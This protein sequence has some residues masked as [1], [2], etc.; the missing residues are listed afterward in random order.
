MTISKNESLPTLD[1]QN[2]A[3]QLK[4]QALSLIGQLAGE[5]WSDHNSSDPGITILEVLAFAISDL[6][7]RLKFPIEDLL[8]GIPGEEK[9]ELFFAAQSILPSNPVTLIDHRRALIDIDGV[10]NANLLTHYEKE[11]A[12]QKATG[13]FDI[14]LDFED[15]IYAAKNKWSDVIYQVRQ[16]FVSQRNVNEDIASIQVATKKYVALTM[17]IELSKATDPVIVLAEILSRIAENIAPSINTYRHEQLI[18]KG[19]AGNEIFDGPLLEQGF[20]FAEDVEKIAMPL[21]LY[22]SDILASVRDIGSLNN[23]NHFSFLLDADDEN[24]IAAGTLGKMDTDSLHWRRDIQKNH[25]ASLNLDKTYDELILTIDGKIFEK[26][27]L[28]SI[29]KQQEDNRKTIELGHG[30]PAITQYVN[31]QYRQLKQYSSIQHQ[32][33]ALYKLAEKRLN[34]AVTNTAMAQILQLKGFLTLFDQVLSDQFA[35]LETLKTLLALP[36]QP[37]FYSL[38]K[39]FS[40]MLASESLTPKDIEQFWVNVNKLPRT[41]VSQPI[42]D[43]SGM[44]TLLG[45]YFESY[46]NTGFQNQAEGIFSFVQLDR[47]KRSVEHL[48][49]RFS[50]TSLDASLLKYEAVFN[51]YISDLKQAPNAIKASDNCQNENHA[52]VKKLVSL[53]QVVDLVLLINDYPKLSKLR[54]G[55][56]DYLL[57]NPKHN[58]SG[59]LIQRIMRFLGLL[60]LDEMPLATNNKEGVYLIESELLRFGAF[61]SSNTNSSQYKKDQLYFVAPKWPSRFANKE[62]RFLLESQIVKDCPVHMQ[63]FVIYLPRDMMS[64][65]ERLYFSWLNAMSKL[66]LV[67]KDLPDTHADLTQEKLKLVVMLSELLRTF[68]SAPEKLFTQVLQSQSLASIVK[69]LNVWLNDEELEKLRVLSKNK[70]TTLSDL[71]NNLLNV[72][73]KRFKHTEDDNATEEEQ[74]LYDQIVFSI[75]Q[76]SLDSLTKPFPISR[77]KIGR[78]FRVGYKPL[79]YLK[80]AY[81]IGNGIINPEAENNPTFTLGIKTPHTI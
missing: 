26:P 63:P 36:D 59:G 60:D 73:K 69:E 16:R 43:I 33:P 13:S 61:K 11:G 45:D 55:G 81:P 9:P 29:K 62:F 75:C 57:S 32:L 20:I 17:N 34:G 71:E 70:N 44:G 18:E 27:P 72:I 5:S 49:S 53:K 51:H 19:I 15:G 80:A 14:I 2:N 66:P 50:E 41:Q 78:T 4:Q 7:E 46:S 23:I 56:G 48:F 24:A 22:S 37:V 31:G 8:Q 12:D 42:T 3:D 30:I 40:Q 67:A 1:H 38:A 54:G 10:K 21:T 74:A 35:Q 47:L 28:D 52:L 76:K 6:S 65:F 79:R 64:L 58:H 39:T 77:S 25:I 68:F